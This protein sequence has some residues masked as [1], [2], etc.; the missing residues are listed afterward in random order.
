MTQRVHIAPAP[1]DE[2]IPALRTVFQHLPEEERAGRVANALTLICRNELD[3]RGILT[4]RSGLAIIGAVVAIRLPGAG[5]LLWPP[6]AVPPAPAETVEDALMRAAVAWLREGGAKVVQ[7]LLRPEDHFLAGPLLRDDFAHVTDLWYFRRPLSDG[8]QTPESPPDPPLSFQPYPRAD[9]RV[10]GQTLLRTYE[11]TRDCPELNGVR[12]AEEIL[13]GHRAQGNH[14]ADL[15]WLAF[16]GERPAGV[17]LLTEMPEWDA[18]DLSYVGVVPEARRK[19]VGRRLTLHGLQLARGRGVSQV[20]LAVDERNRP[21]WDMYR[22][23]G[24]VPQERRKAYL[25]VWRDGP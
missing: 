15:W 16:Q 19:G 8:P 21:A 4:A 12:N 11:R 23:L 13:A 3:P 20:T 5:G 25:R 18:L 14:D 7:A 1:P 24:F 9:R 10:F 17:L 2:R 6:R 22:A